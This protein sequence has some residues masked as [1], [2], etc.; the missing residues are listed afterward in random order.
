MRTRLIREICTHVCLLVSAL[1]FLT[2][3]GTVAAQENQWRDNKD[4]AFPH[5]QKIKSFSVE[6]TDQALTYPDYLVDIPDEHT[7]LLPQWSWSNL[8][9]GLGPD[10]YLLFGSSAITGASGGA[11]VL[12]T[13]DLK[14]FSSAAARGYSEQVITAPVA[15]RNCDPAYDNEFDENY[16]APGSV[17]QDPTLPPGNLIMI[18]EAENHCPLGV[19]NPSFYATVGFARSSDNGRSWPLPPVNQEFGDAERHPIFKDFYPELIPNTPISTESLGDALPSAF[20]DI[21]R[22]GDA[23]LY[24]TYNY[25]KGSNQPLPKDGAIRVGRG[26][27]G[28]VSHD[29]GGDWGTGHNSQ[30]QFYKW[31][32]GTFSQPGIAGLDSGVIP[33]TGCTGRQ[34]MSGITYND[35]LGVYLMIF[36]CNPSSTTPEGVTHAAWYYSTATSLDLEDWTP[37]QPILNSEHEIVAPCNT[38]DPKEPSGSAFDGFY[39]SFMSPGVPAGH[40]RLTGLA[41]FLNGCDTGLPRKFASRKFTITT[42]P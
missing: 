25:A 42:E 17:L 16:A 34:S 22:E 32:N 21:N 29:F 18:Y 12:Q 20:V 1:A 24:V 10:S 37:P 19:H 41:F 3:A 9:Q 28:E 35:D 31:Y 33:T 8:W 40:T 30:L 14:N 13:T 11:V 5:H 36:V 2:L 38:T 7:T 26:K 15:F 6:E 39:P 27:L 23:Y 4:D